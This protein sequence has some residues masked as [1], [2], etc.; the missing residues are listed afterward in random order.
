M[1]GTATPLRNEVKGAKI[2]EALQKDVTAIGYEMIEK[3]VEQ[4]E[5]T[6]GYVKQ[7]VTL[8]VEFAPGNDEPGVFAC[9]AKFTASGSQVIHKASI[10]RDGAHH[11]LTMF[12]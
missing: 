3:L 5:A 11:Q 12:V 1:A 9:F 8:K 6:D 7:S 4:V 10:N 2:I